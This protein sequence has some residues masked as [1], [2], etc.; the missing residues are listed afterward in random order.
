GYIPELGTGLD[1]QLPELRERLKNTEPDFG[2]DMVRT[3]GIGEWAAPFVAQNSTTNPNGYPV[4]YESQ[5]LVAKAR[6]HNENAQPTNPNIESVIAAY[7]AVDAEFGIK[8]LR[9]ALHHVE[10]ATTSQILRLKAMN[11][12]VSMSGFKWLNTVR[13]TDGLH[14]GP[15]FKDILAPG[16]HAGLHDAGAPT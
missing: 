5:R 4:W 12:V 10:Q 6:W 16:T 9:W 8:D 11:C 1:K 7:E 13:R 15:F 2:D 14:V 3:G